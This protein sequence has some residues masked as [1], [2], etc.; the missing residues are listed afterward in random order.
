MQREN[1]PEIYILKCFILP[2]LDH[3]F[4]SNFPHDHYSYFFKLLKLLKLRAEL[5]TP[6]KMNSGHYSKFKKYT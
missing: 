1:K 3:L 2:N 6:A 4:L 5:P